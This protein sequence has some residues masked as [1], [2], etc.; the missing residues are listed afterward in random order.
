MDE[1]SLHAQANTIRRFMMAGT[2]ML[3]VTL[4]LMAVAALVPI[5]TFASPDRSHVNDTIPRIASPQVDI[6]PLLTRVAGSRLIRPAQVQA[7][8]KDSGAGKMLLARLKLQSVVSLGG[9]QI[10]YVRVKDEGTQTVRVGGR[11]LDFV[12]ES[13]DPGHVKLSLEGVIVDLR[14]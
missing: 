14:Y 11:L 1:L 5:K 4:S 7:A 10:A 2:I 8:V 3:F 6:G 9:E 12:V 13:I